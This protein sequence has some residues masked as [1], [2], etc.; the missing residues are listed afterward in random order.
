MLTADGGPMLPVIE[1]VV[2]QTDRCGAPTPALVGIWKS[3]P[4]NTV[5]IVPNRAKQS[6][7]SCN[8]PSSAFPV[9]D[10]REVKQSLPRPV[11]PVKNP[12][13]GR[14]RAVDGNART[15]ISALGKGNDIHCR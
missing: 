12:V 15:L 7:R 10:F 8:V 11:L 6:V 3:S 13:A 14:T 4:L 5:R 2:C 1:R 9:T